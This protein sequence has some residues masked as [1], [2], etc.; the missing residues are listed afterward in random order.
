MRERSEKEKEREERVI[1]TTASSDN[2]SI[3]PSEL[4]AAFPQDRGKRYYPERA[5]GVRN[6]G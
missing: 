1:V 4:P 3:D 2:R 5:C 6:R